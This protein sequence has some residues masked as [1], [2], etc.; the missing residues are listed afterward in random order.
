[1]TE[2]L[3]G[4]VS[5]IAFA[6]VGMVLLVV[7]FFMVDLLTP[8]RLGHAIFTE[9]NRDAALVLGASQL[10]LGLILATSIFQADGDTWEN[11][12]DTLA[13]G[14]VGV[15]LLG[16]AFAVLD[17][18]TPGKLG[19]LVTDEHEDPAVWVTVAMQLAVG[20]IVAASLT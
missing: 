16:L 15:A 12:L 5:T 11:L 9:R 19:A 20:L 13:Y 8:G 3:D 2:L 14:L 17:L 18:I 10:S 6:G 1:M 7:G 4:L